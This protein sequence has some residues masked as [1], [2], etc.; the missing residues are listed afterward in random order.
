MNPG[1]HLARGR[2][3]AGFTWFAALRLRGAAARVGHGAAAHFTDDT[4][5]E[6]IADRPTSVAYRVTGS[7]ATGVTETPLL[8][9]CLDSDASP[10]E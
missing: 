4:L 2:W 3:N 6:L 1:L 5:T 10:V 7:G 9:R 8:T